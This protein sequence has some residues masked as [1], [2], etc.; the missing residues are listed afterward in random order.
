MYILEYLFRVCCKAFYRHQRNR[1]HHWKYI[2]RLL[3]GLSLFVTAIEKNDAIITQWCF[4]EIKH[5]TTI[6]QKGY[7]YVKCPLYDGK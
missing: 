6:Q 4:I 1:L 5:S 7:Y 2:M 3:E